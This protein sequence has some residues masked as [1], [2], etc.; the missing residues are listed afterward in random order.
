MET[1]KIKEGNKVIA[2]FMG[3]RS[4]IIN[5]LEYWQAGEYGLVTYSYPDYDNWNNLM[6]VI[7]KISEIFD[8]NENEI[9]EYGSH[10]ELFSCT[11]FADIGYVLKCVIE[12]INW[13]N[14]NKEKLS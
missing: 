2:E 5:D 8:E 13:Y 12:F 11:I 7:K 14:E 6:P 3:W 9:I 1:E 10:L 4:K